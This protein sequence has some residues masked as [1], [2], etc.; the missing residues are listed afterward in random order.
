MLKAG[1][2]CIYVGKRGTYR[3]KIE[4]VSRDGVWYTVK[5]GKNR[6]TTGYNS[7]YPR[8]NIFRRLWYA[9]PRRATI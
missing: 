5:V 6:I 9:V 8:I 3:A 1:D 7:V 2:R 4:A